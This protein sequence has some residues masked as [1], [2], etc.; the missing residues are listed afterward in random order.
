MARQARR[1]T[2]PELELRRALH[3]LGLRYRVDKKPIE[4]MRTRADIV[5]G[6]A[7]VAV[8]VDGC[9]WHSC[10]AHRTTP[11]NNQGW[12]EAKLAANVAR[13]KRVDEELRQRGWLPVR[14]WEHEDMPL[15]ARR[16]ERQVRRRAPAREARA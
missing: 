3:R 14:V 16:I 13:D 2:K 11:K 9:F 12:W 10:P 7:K 1:D 4:G 6:P 5:F 15:A 8:F